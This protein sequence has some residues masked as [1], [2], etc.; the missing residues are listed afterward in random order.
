M[1]YSVSAPGRKSGDFGVSNQQST[2]FRIPDAGFGSEDISSMLILKKLLLPTVLLCLLGSCGN[3]G[4]LYLPEDAANEATN[5]TVENAESDKE[6]DSSEDED[7]T[8]R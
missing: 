5:P 2:R 1:A 3:R 6:D 8:G 4:P 7:A